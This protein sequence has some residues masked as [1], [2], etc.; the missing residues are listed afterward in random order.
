[1]T[2]NRRHRRGRA[3]NGVLIVDK[4]TG[5]TSNETIQR[6]KSIYRARKVG[7]TGSLDPLATGVLPVCFGEA[8]KFSR[9]L[10]DATKR[11]C[12]TIRLG[13]ETNTGDSEG[14]VVQVQSTA[15][16]TQ[17]RVEEALTGFRGTFWQIPPMFS[18]IKVSSRPMY[19]L[20]R[21]G[22]EVEREP[23]SVTV[24]SNRL[25]SFADDKITLDVHCS[26]GTYMRSIAADLGSELGCGGH[27]C[28]LRRTAAGHFEVDESNTFEDLRLARSRDRLDELLL[29][30]SSTV[31]GCPPLT[32]TEEMAYMVRHGVHPPA[33]ESSVS[34]LV[35]L[36]GSDHAFMGVGEILENGCIAPRRLT[37]A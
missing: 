23:R 27:V 34:G 18:A 15:Q 24:F 2:R 11:Y 10:L 36:Y 17:Q 29:P 1:M 22:I 7:H 20:A 9:Y 32:L 33:P 13:I 12:V 21:N 14:E 6:V 19:E 31:A 3:V 8:T 30:M 26:K 25:V 5:L 35:R 4:P 16:I 28:D 37:A